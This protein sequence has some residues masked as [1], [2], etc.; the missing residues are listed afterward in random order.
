MKK[1]FVGI[2]CSV[3]IAAFSGCKSH[4]DNT[5]AVLSGE[6]ESTNNENP[7]IDAPPMLTVHY[8]FE[9]KL[10]KEEADAYIKDIESIA[11]VTNSIDLSVVPTDNF[12]SNFLEKGTK[13]YFVDKGIVAVYD[14][15]ENY[16]AAL[17]VAGV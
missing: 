15:A 12:S 17:L 9:E 7:D 1:I 10:S 3:L 2:L 4:P 5:D 11:E 14:D 16:Y 6:T 8:Y 13:L